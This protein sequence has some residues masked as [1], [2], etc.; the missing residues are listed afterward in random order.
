MGR[1]IISR[2]VCP[3][4]GRGTTRISAARRG[5]SP[6]PNTTFRDPSQGRCRWHVRRPQHEQHESG[7][8]RRACARLDEGREEAMR[9]RR[10]AAWSR[11]G[12]VG[13]TKK[14]LEL[15]SPSVSSLQGWRK[16]GRGRGAGRWV[17]Q[18][19]LRQATKHAACAARARSSGRLTAAR[20][21][22]RRGLVQLRALPR[23]AR[24][25]R[26]RASVAVPTGTSH[27]YLPRLSLCPVRA[28]FWNDSSFRSRS[29][30]QS[31]SYDASSLV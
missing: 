26:P 21:W 27:S 5:G 25:L 7:G 11:R 28:Y 17:L 8:E 9:I 13:P 20:S 24:A 14:V 10:H 4:R 22:P 6:A 30:S 15:A 23:A 1:C 18:L 3:P 12:V 29:S 16:C 31:S 2:D 19:R